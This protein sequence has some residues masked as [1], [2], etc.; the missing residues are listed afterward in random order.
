MSSTGTGEHPYYEHAESVKGDDCEVEKKAKESYKALA[1]RM[2]K[3]IR[4]VLL[5]GCLNSQNYYSFYSLIPY[6]FIHMY[7]YLWIK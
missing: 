6:F 1:S 2:Q 4:V 3:V 5:R 7:L